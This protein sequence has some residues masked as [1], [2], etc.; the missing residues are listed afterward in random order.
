MNSEPT[1]S[2]DVYRNHK[3]M[4]YIFTRLEKSFFSSSCV[5]KRKETR[6]E[7][8]RFVLPS[9][10]KIDYFRDGRGS[11]V[12]SEMKRMTQYSR[13]RRKSHARELLSSCPS[14]ISSNIKVS[15]R[16]ES[17]GKIIFEK[18]NSF[19]SKRLFFCFFKKKSNK[20]IRNS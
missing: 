18:I 3:Y 14:W 9:R 6:K 13:R 20:R 8:D 19:A 15:A 4:I 1:E 5:E 11:T 10:E 12:S 16:C 2:A 17:L 7:F